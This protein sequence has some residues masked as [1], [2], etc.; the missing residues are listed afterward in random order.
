MVAKLLML[1]VTHRITVLFLMVAMTLVSVMGLPQ[2]RVDTGFSSLISDDDPDRPAYIETAEEFGSDNRTLIYVRDSGLWSTKKLTALQKL[3]EKL[4]GL[5]FV[6]RVDDLFTLRTIRGDTN[7]LI[8]KVVLD[9]VPVDHAAIEEA[10]ADALDNPILVGNLISKDGLVTALMVSVRESPTEEGYDERVNEVIESILDGFRPSFEQLFQIGPPRINSELKESLFNDLTLLAPLSALMLVVM[11]LLFM[12]SVT[13]AVIPLVTSVLSITWTLGMM[14]WIGLPLNIL[15]AMLPSLVVVIGS[16]ED[17]HMVAGYLRGLMEKGTEQQAASRE[18]ATRFMI[19][20]LGVPLLLTVFTTGLGFASNIFSSMG[21]VRDFAIASSFA[22]FANGVIS[23][24][25]VPSMMLLFGPRKSRLVLREER[26]SGLP[27]LVDRLFDATR[28]RFA[29]SVVILTVLMCG[30]FIFQASKL[31]VTNDPLSYFRGDRALIQ[32]TQQIQKDL[33]GMKVF[34]VTLDA[35]RD[36]AFLDPG[37]LALVK[38]IQAFVEKQGVFDRTISIV[39]HISLVNREFHRGQEAYYDIPAE[40]NLVAQYLLF[41]HRNDLSAYVSHDYRRANIVVRHNITDSNTLNRHIAELK[42]VTAQ[43][44]GINVKT[45]V[46]GENLLINA[47]AESLMVAQV[48]SLGLLLLVIFLIMSAMFTSLKGGLIALIPNLIP[49]ILMFGVMGFL[50]IPLNPG[51]AMVA[52]IAIG[53]AVDGTIHLFS[54]YNELCRTTSDYDA[55]VRQTVR[56]EAT[57]VVATSLAL[58]FGFGILLLSNF[59]VVAQFGALSALTVIFAVVSDLLI[60]PIIMSR[61]RLIGLYQILSMSMQREVLAKSPL[62][63]DMTNYQIR[64][65]ILISEMRTFQPGDLLVEQGST[66]RSMYLI[67]TGMTE[68]ILRGDDGEKT[69]LAA[70]GPGQVFGEIGYIRETQRTADVRALTKVNAL[71]FDYEKQRQDLKF[72]PHI[73]AKLNFNISVIL[74]E[75]LADVVEGMQK[76]KREKDA[77]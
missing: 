72:F 41:F 11:I 50:G 16:T 24:L 55:A 29:R 49:I 75:R 69:R 21:L 38:K 53:I 74:G 52:V 51:T 64:K 19:K 2:L 54:R 73:V 33:S 43:I 62:F 28:Q 23:I 56:E 36:K 14:G 10:R 25:L 40:R 42:R 61:V 67:L 31:Y 35:Q 30:F 68:V 15:S 60:T 3:H 32:E 6:E 9:E 39:D 66:G 65:A 20:H 7:G 46:V 18:V 8:S 37:N 70:L 57:P 27:G 76:Q 1:G 22:I 77:S 34:Y 44:A 58:S 12:R 71:R 63:R 17:T 47:A 48:K 45:H 5:D 13:A 4:E 26:I 59:T